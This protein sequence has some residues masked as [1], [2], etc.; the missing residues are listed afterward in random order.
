MPCA[1]ATYPW[2]QCRGT[3]ATA[4]GLGS[5]YVACPSAHPESGPLASVE[6]RTPPWTAR[7][8]SSPVALRG[9]KHW[10]SSIIRAASPATLP[11]LRGARFRLRLWC[12]EIIEPLENPI[13]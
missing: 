5:A 6:P 4:A 13:F 7:Q 2:L 3:A 11:L 10:G 12:D 1:P 9:T 8:R